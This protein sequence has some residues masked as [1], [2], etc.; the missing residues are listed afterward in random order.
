MSRRQNL[1]QE[2]ELETL[3]SLTEHLGTT[4]FIVKA[5]VKIFS[6]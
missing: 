6:A 3:V 4:M 2:N 5:I 1:S